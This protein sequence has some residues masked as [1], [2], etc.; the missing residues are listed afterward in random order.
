MPKRVEQQVIYERNNSHFYK[1]LFKPRNPKKYRGNAKNIVF[2]SHWELEYMRMLD[3]KD[4]C[5]SWASEEFSIKYYHPIKLCYKRYFPDFFVEMRQKDGKI[6]KAIVEIKPANQIAQPRRKKNG[7]MQRFIYES[8]TFA[9][10]RAKWEAAV[11]F[12][13]EHKLKFYV[14]TKDNKEQFVLLNE[15]QLHL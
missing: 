2:R 8:M 3:E 11:K 15:E 7:K 13:K 12:C 1:G 10:N 14:V 6:F 4:N 5:I 9:V